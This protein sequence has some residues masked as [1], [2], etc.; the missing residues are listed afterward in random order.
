[1][2]VS[3]KQKIL[4]IFDILLLKQNI[5]REKQVIKQ[6]Q[7]LKPIENKKYNIETISDSKIYTNKVFTKLLSLSYLIFKKNLQQI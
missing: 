5:I 1:M 4:N 6:K 3:T 2:R 7:E